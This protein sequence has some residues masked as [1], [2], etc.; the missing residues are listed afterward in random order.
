MKMRYLFFFLFFLTIIVQANNNPHGKDRVL[1][2]AL[3]QYSRSKGIA[4]S[5]QH[6]ISPRIIFENKRNDTATYYVVGF[7]NRPGLVFVS[8]SEQDDPIIGITE[9]SEFDTISIPPALKALLRS[10]ERSV[11]NQLRNPTINEKSVA[12]EQEKEVAG[13]LTGPELFYEVNAYSFYDTIGPLM[14]T[15]WG[16]G[17]PYNWLCPRLDKVAYTC[18]TIAGCG[19]IAMAQVMRYN[20]YPPEYNWANMPNSIDSNNWDIANLILDCGDYADANHGCSYTETYPWDIDNAMRRFGYPDAKYVDDI[21]DNCRHEDY[22][23]KIREQIRDGFPVIV[24]GYEEWN[25]ADWHI[26]VLDGYT[27]Q[28]YEELAYFHMNWGWEG[29]YDGWYRLNNSNPPGDNGPYNYNQGVTHLI[30]PPGMVSLIAPEQGNTVGSYV[31]FPVA[32][33][34]FGRAADLDSALIILNITDYRQKSSISNDSNSVVIRVANQP[35]N[36]LVFAMLKTPRVLYVD[37][38]S[39]NYSITVFG[40]KDNAYKQKYHSESRRF[41]LKSGESASFITPDNA[42]LCQANMRTTIS[43]QYNMN[44]L[45]EIEPTFTI[46]YTKI[47][48]PVSS[49]MSGTIVVD[50]KG[51]S[52]DWM[53]PPNLEGVYKLEAQ[54]KGDGNFR[55]YSEPFTITSRPVF[56]IMV[57]VSNTSWLPG[58]QMNISWATNLAENIRIKVTRYDDWNPADT[59]IVAESTPN[60]GAYIWDIPENIKPGVLY[61]IELR[62]ITNTHIYTGTA[63][64]TIKNKITI[65]NPVESVDWEKGE[66]YLIKWKDNFAE[67]VHIKLYKAGVFYTNI[68]LDTPSDG[69]FSWA[70]PSDFLANSAYQIR[71]SKV[72]DEQFLPRP[73]TLASLNL[74]TLLLKN[75]NRISIGKKG[76][77]IISNGKPIPALFLNSNCLITASH[78]RRFI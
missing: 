33:Q 32:W 12:L 48:G 23:R 13:E 49:P 66:E 10:H 43:W 62:C 29:S 60:D 42:T 69:A 24:D 51:T 8:A 74:F 3:R 35:G 14:T 54:Y 34:T 55:F 7:E 70:I 68:V 18:K 22:I 30:K 28:A 45:P 2:L 58:S 1:K 67:N 59:I 26:F 71:I 65:E 53:I 46:S 52:Y 27:G 72:D 6:Q 73:V 40:N 31:A 50:H 44:V 19:P 5:E 11:M 25:I 41:Y 78:P 16:Q 75:P 77:P 64:F 4:L 9:T 20:E 63:Y 36:N 76:R 17:S 57:P 21:D 47:S 56:N 37:S 15:E 39:A 61:A 38:V